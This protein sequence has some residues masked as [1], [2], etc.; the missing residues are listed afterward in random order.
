MPMMD[1][2]STTAYLGRLTT[3]SSRPP[4]SLVE[5]RRKALAIAKEQEEAEE[6]KHAKSLN[7]L[8]DWHRERTGGS[9]SAS[10]PDSELLDWAMKLPEMKGRGTDGGPEGREPAYSED[11]SALLDHAAKVTGLERPS[12]NAVRN[13]M[14]AHLVK[15]WGWSAAAFSHYDRNNRQRSSTTL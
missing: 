14:I 3:E 6:A 13:G 12:L 7:D 8:R 15:S 2:R 11:F 4:P 10:L 1:L 9:E 5:E